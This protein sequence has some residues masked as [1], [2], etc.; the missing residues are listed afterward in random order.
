MMLVILR[1][2]CNMLQSG[3]IDYRILTSFHGSILKLLPSF[4]I[5]ISIREN[6]GNRTRK[7]RDDVGESDKGVVYRSMQ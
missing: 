1:R 7:A 2:S 3:N 4:Q 5:L 6:I